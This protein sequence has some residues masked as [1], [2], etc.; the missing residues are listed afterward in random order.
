MPASSVR[1]T[2]VWPHAAPP[3]LAASSS[4]EDGEGYLTVKEG[5]A[6]Y[7]QWGQYNGWG[8]GK[9]ER[10]GDVWDEG[11][12]PM[13]FWKA[14]CRNKLQKHSMS[15]LRKSSG[16]HSYQARKK[17]TPYG[18][19]RPSWAT[20]ERVAQVFPFLRSAPT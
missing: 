18:S 20:S 13:S 2:L 14:S 16:A 19:C 12:V 10:S 7:M 17:R 4:E 3:G 15:D 6:V 5:D 9:V 11:F 8:T 1:V